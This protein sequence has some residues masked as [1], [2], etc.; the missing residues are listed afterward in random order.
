MAT[1]LWLDLVP[2]AVLRDAVMLVLGWAAFSTFLVA[3]AGAWIAFAR[4]RADARSR[5]RHRRLTHPN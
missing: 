3:S 4:T 2:A 1:L 5:P